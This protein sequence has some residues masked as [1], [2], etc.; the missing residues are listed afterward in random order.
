MTVIGRPFPKGVSG[1]PGGRPKTRPFKDAID[2][3]IEKAEKGEEGAISL[4]DI[5][6]ALFTE[7]KGGNVA[8]MKEL[9][10]R[11]DGKVAQGL[12]HSGPDG[13]P[14]NKEITDQE[15]CRIIAHIMLKADEGK[16]K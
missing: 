5:A 11:T 1:N 4:D 12:E 7:A 15:L 16:K 9:A 13:E 10:D 6:L 2:R 8:A 14:M 3:A